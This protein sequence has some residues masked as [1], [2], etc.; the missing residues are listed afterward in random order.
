ML[1]ISSD[2]HYGFNLCGLREGYQGIGLCPKGSLQ[3]PGDFVKR[4]AHE[5]RRG[6][7]YVLV[8]GTDQEELR[9][10]LKSTRDVHAK[11]QWKAVVKAEPLTV[12]GC[13]DGK[14]RYCQR[15]VEHRA[16]LIFGSG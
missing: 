4:W 3:P 2:S 11:R 6:S 7:R 12:G 13:F 16:A 8:R 9:R 10:T 1:P 5:C 14:R 15:T